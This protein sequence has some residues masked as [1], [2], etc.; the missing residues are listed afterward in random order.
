MEDV[1][2]KARSTRNA[3]KESSK[4][5]EY[6]GPVTSTT[7]KQKMISR[8]GKHKNAYYLDSGTSIHILFDQE[9]LQDI[10]PLEEAKL[11]ATGS[12]GVLELHH[13]GSLLKA[14]EHLPLPKKGYYYNQNA[15]ENLLSLGQLAD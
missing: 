7:P 14:F 1:K 11:I 10:D 12:V 2:E 5:W 13:I 8:A 4:P 3:E 6:S 15:M 9:T